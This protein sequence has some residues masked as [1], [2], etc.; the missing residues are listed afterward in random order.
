M[1]TTVYIDGVQGALS[2]GQTVQTGGTQGPNA[3]HNSTG[4]AGEFIG[5]N[6]TYLKISSATLANEQGIDST[7]GELQDLPK[8]INLVASRAT[9]VVVNNAVGDTN[10]I[11][12]GPHGWIT[13]TGTLDSAGLQTAIQALGGQL[14]AATVATMS[15]SLVLS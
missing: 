3:V 13:T 14:A 15:D 5:A 8:L 6:F 4:A 12:E 10:M 2:A 7:T 11:L 9:I 1:A